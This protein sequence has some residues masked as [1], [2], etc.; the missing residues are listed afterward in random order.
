MAAQ[1]KYDPGIKK[2]AEK[3]FL[4]TSYTRV[5]T[6]Q[7]FG[8]LGLRVTEKSIRYWWGL[9]PKPE[10]RGTR[11]VAPKN[12]LAELENDLAASKARIKH[13]E[14][15]I[16]EKEDAV[17]PE[18]LMTDLILSMRENIENPILGVQASALRAVHAVILGKPETPADK[19]DSTDL[20][21]RIDA[22]KEIKEPV[23]TPFAEGVE[24]EPPKDDQT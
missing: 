16:V 15:K 14:S 23:S 20:V 8:D 12:K 17:S 22:Q 5:E 1:S 10:H 7:F 11:G 2:C 21:A 18:S 19:D 3:L 24:P 6:V 13:L 4:D 9:V